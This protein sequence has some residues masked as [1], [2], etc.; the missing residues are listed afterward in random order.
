MP[1]TF[2]CDTDLANRYG[3]S[4]NT[5]W[6]WARDYEGFPKPVKLSPGSTR[7]K[8]SEIEQWET[9]RAEVPA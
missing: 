1:H 5:I 2:L 7:W 3:V 4:R 8:L 6:R 9:A